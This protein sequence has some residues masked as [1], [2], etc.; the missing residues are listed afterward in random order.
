MYTAVEFG[1][2]HAS[3][4]NFPSSKLFER[5]AK[6]AEAAKDNTHRG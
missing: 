5:F 3:G 4:A 6:R 1:W 2:L